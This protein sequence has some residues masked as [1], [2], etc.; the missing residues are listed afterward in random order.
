MRSVR[1]APR[2]SVANRLADMEK[3]RERRNKAAREDDLQFSRDFLSASR[4]VCTMIDED[5]TGEI[6]YPEFVRLLFP[7]VDEL[8]EWTCVGAAGAAE[9]EADGTEGIRQSTRPGGC[10]PSRRCARRAAS[11]TSTSC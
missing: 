1:C 5:E 4:R 3:E 10:P 7:N 2:H 9:G 6:D 8:P 11:A